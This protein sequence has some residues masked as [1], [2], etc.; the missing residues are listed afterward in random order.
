VDVDDPRAVAAACAALL[1]APPDERLALRAHCR[2]VALERYTWERNATGLLGLY[3]R[4]AEDA[5]GAAPG[6]GAREGAGVGA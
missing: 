4:L 6:S 3:R 5:R 1:S 2:R